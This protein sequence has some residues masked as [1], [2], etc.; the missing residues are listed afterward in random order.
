MVD[1]IARYNR[2]R[3]N[4]L[5]EAGV[6][7]ARPYLDLDARSA[8]ELVCVELPENDR[9]RCSQ[10]RHAGSVISGNVVSHGATAAGRGGSGDMNQVLETDWHAM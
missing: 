2:G 3:W 6:A 10:P 7:Y 5:A 8:R 4:E 1:E 9:A